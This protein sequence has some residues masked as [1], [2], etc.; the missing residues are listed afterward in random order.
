M[1]GAQAA[2]RQRAR[3]LEAE[4]IKRELFQLAKRVEELTTT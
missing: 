4:K 3:R 1:A 2:A